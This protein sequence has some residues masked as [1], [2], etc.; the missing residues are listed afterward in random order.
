MAESHAESQHMFEMMATI[1]ETKGVR[2]D[3]GDALMAMFMEI[4]HGPRGEDD[5]HDSGVLEE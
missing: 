1:R 3:D 2:G 4:V 5:S